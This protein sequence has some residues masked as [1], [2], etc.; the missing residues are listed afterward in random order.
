[1]E[2]EEVEVNSERWFDLTPLL[3]EEFRDIIGYEGLYQVSNYG[4]VKS[5]NKYK[6]NFLINTNSK[7]D[8]SQVL[9]QS[10]YYGYCSVCLSVNE[11]KTKKRVNRLVAETFLNKQDFKSMP[12]EDRNTINLN[13]LQV[14]HKDEFD[15]TNNRVDNLEWCTQRYNANYGTHIERSSVGKYKKIL[16]CDLNGNPIR[17]WN[18]AKQVQIELGYERSNICCNLKDKIKCAYGYKWKYLEEENDEII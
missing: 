8:S 18:S 10:I 4:R 3:N 12:D 16:Q 1:M 14:N 17:E 15:K 9:K 11:N 5:I 7:K 6:N 2:Y 13:N